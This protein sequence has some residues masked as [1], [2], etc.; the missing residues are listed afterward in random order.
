MRIRHY[1]PSLVV[2]TPAKLNLFL[3]VRGKRP[4]GFHEI[5]TVMVSVGLYDTLRFTPAAS[6]QTR[7]TC[8]RACARSRTRTLEA[9]GAVVP[10]GDD[11]LVV[12]AARL[13]RAE[14]GCERGADMELVKRIPT[15]AG[16]GGGSSDAAATLV[17]LNRMWGLG[18]ASHELHSLAAR[19][20]SDVNYF[21][22]SP[23][24]AVCRG[25]GEQVEPARLG[26]ALHFV[27]AQPSSGLSTAEV[28]RNWSAAGDLRRSAALLGALR[29]GRLAAV[30]GGLHNA[31]ERPAKHLNPEVAQ[32]LERL[33]RVLPSSY[34][35]SG[36]G[37][38]CYVLC[39]TRR[40]ARTLGARLRS[41]AAGRVWIVSSAV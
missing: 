5:E 6:G 30:A 29:D 17:G 21:I 16:M 18:L 7:F 2:H 14:T 19:L 32:L 10:P 9:S 24:L 33:A 37:T 22:E 26:T 20:G 27:V 23:P 31:L 35:M 28:Y 36:S 25:R 12:R 40:Q 41:Q 34:R 39:R 3:E 13:L 1:G 4:D 8:R 11:N 15:A 38:A